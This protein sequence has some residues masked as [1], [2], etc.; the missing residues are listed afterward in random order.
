MDALPLTPSGK[1]DRKA[2]PAP[3]GTAFAHRTYEAPLGPI[4]QAIAGIWTDVLKVERVGREDHFFDLG[5]HS[6]LAVRVLSRLRQTLSVE[7]GVSELFAHPVLKEL[8]LV[9]QRSARSVLPP[10]TKFARSGRLPLSFAQQ[11]LWF[12]AQLEGVSE[13]YHVSLG[14]RLLGDLDPAALRRAV[15]RIVERHEVLRTR[16]VLVAG[17]PVQQVVEPDFGLRE[18]DA[19]EAQLDQ[20]Q[21]QEADQPFDLERDLPIRGRLIRLAD[22]DHVLL[23][24]MHH[25]ATDG[26]S[27]GVFITELSA[28]Y[29]A[30]RAGAEDPLPP[31]ALQYADYAAWQR[32]YCPLDQIGYWREMLSG[33]P[34]VLELPC[35]R[36]RPAQHDYSGGHIEIEWDE[37][38]TSGLRALSRR[39]QTTLF[40]V[41]LT[42]W[43]IVLGRFSSQGTV[44]IGTPVAN[45]TRAELEPL[46]GCF[47]NTLAI[48]IDME[49]DTAVGELLRHVNSLVLGAQQHQAVPFEQVV[50]AINPSRSLAHSPLFQVMLAWQS[51]DVGRLDLPGL[52]VLPAGSQ[53][54]IAKFFLTLNLFEG[55]DR[56]AGRVEY[57]TRLFDRATVERHASSLRCV[58]QAMV[59]DENAS[60]GRLGLFT[61]EEHAALLAYSCAN[62][63]PF[64][65]EQCIHQLFQQQ[66]ESN[67]HALAVIHGE[68]SLTY[69][70][71]NTQANQLAHYLLE[72]G[73]RPGDR[74][75]IA[76]E[77]SLELVIAQLGILKCGAAY[78]PLDP[79]APGER[80]RWMVQDAGARIVLSELRFAARTNNPPGPVSSES[81]AYVMYTSGST[82]KPK[83]VLVPHRAISRLVLN[84]GYAQLVSEDR[85]GFNA[86]P[87]FDASTFELWSALL[88]G[89][90]SVIIDQATLLDGPALSSFLARERV[91]VL[92]LVAGLLST[93][94][95]LPHLRYLL[96]GG[97]VVDDQ[98][99]QKVLQHSRPEHLI[100]CYGPTESTTFAITHEVKVVEPGARSVPLGRPIGNTRIYILDRYGETVPVGVAGEICIAGEGLAHGYLNRPALT[101][102]RFVP[103]ARSSEPGARMYR[104][105]DLGH[106]RRD[107]TVEFLGRADSQVKIRGYR[108]E[109]GEIQA[110]LTEHPGIQEAVVLART[111]CGADKYLVAY[112]VEA[113][114]EKLSAEAL[115]AHASLMLPE[116]MVPAAYVALESLPLTA[117]GKLDRKALPK[118]ERAVREYEAAQ[119]EVESTIAHLWCKL[120]R[121]ERV[122][123]HD[124][125]FELGGHSLM[126]SRLVHA[127]ASAGIQVAA[128]DLFSHPTIASLRE[129]LEQKSASSAADEAIPV[130]SMGRQRPLF[131]VHDYY[132]LGIEFAALAQHIDSDIPVYGL[133]PVPMSERPLRTMQ[134]MALRMTRMIREVQAEGPYRLAGWSFG[135]VLAYEIAAQLC[136]QNQNVEFLGMFDSYCPSLLSRTGVLDDHEPQ[137]GRMEAHRHALQAYLVQPIPVLIHLF[138]ARDRDAEPADESLGWRAALPDQPVRVVTVP[139]T[140]FTLMSPPHIEVLGRAVSAA[141]SQ[142]TLA[143]VTEDMDV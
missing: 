107:G 89:A 98:A 15:A 56:I 88:Q 75:A 130:R 136:A 133:P 41:V 52:S 120:L 8:A 72:C 18:Q 116:H 77:R 135:G 29:G 93:H 122:G 117:H 142:E 36:P 132:G 126:I 35:D 95:E 40:T 134:T 131:L 108:V 26:W 39:H 60:I 42:A 2:T 58:L 21:R 9:L 139:G 79:N 114:G 118:P 44:V 59:A 70:Q 50:E 7:V 143:A 55:N 110:R 68:R 104:S 84:S 37:A 23:I 3:K 137:S 38:L 6:L 115:R 5:G 65:R 27:L 63:A 11:R 71:L 16:I 57:A 80:Q 54:A 113:P 83:G 106:W 85:V 24:T 103:D 17:E 10:I 62:P 94:S 92:H 67:P 76:L 64:P 128:T 78:V 48:R 91:T 20:V 111:D 46:I 86:N 87:A 125:F 140:H 51:N 97:D 19:T 82:G 90:C 47:V 53:H 102:E 43:A 28:L 22:R 33:A 81:V 30:F 32:Q 100:H 1:L 124:N 34:A 12:L 61:R 74:V 105:G 73:I 31:L 13:S 99:L 119:G 141:I 96:T 127:L 112:Y 4:E 14:L 69:E 123:R 109:L 25:I 129:R 45:R 49:G 121:I 138:A 66:V 101:A